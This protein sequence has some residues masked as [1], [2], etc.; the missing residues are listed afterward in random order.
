MTKFWNVL[1]LCC[2]LATPAAAQDLYPS[3]KHVLDN[4][5]PVVITEM[6]GNPMVSVYCLVK[7]GSATEG[8]FLGAGISHFV[9]H[10]LFKTTKKR[11]VGQIAREVQAM[12]GE[13]NATTSQ[14]FT[15][16]TITVPA[17]KFAQALDV[18]VD[19]VSEATFDPAEVEKERTVIFREMDLHWD[20]P[21]SR[22]GR[23]A[24]ENLFLKHPYRYPTI[25]YK[26]LFASITRDE[27][28]AYYKEKYVP[29]NM[30]LS[31]AGGVRAK[32]IM[33]QINGF[34]RLQTRLLSG[35]PFGAGAPTGHTAL[36]GREVRYALYI[37]IDGLPGGQSIG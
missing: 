26:E 20:N 35:T 21:E 6:E 13:I 9:E 8:R 24:F 16:Y 29:N 3:S 27:L 22:L 14:D 32:D 19:Q 25:G 23:L 5:M 28:Y 30:V 12:G 4:G 1:L 33:P 17:D 37:F 18:L 15:I 36:P 7:T 11:K 2:I 31:V 10:M 34:E